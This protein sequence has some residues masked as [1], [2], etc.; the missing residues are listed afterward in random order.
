[1][2]FRKPGVGSWFGWVGHGIGGPE[3][4]HGNSAKSK[5]LIGVPS[6][7]RIERVVGSLPDTCTISAVVVDSWLLLGQHSVPIW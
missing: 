4:E 2:S 5:D 6:C 1:M 3:Q 7:H